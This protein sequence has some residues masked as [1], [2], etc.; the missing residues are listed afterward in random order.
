MTSHEVGGR[1]TKIVKLSI[2]LSE[3][4]SHLADEIRKERKKA[5]KHDNLVRVASLLNEAGREGVEA[6]WEQTEEFHNLWKVKSREYLAKT[7]WK[8]RKTVKRVRIR[9]T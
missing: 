6:Q 3:S 7:E 4:V 5:T 2:N 8:R 1:C 9:G